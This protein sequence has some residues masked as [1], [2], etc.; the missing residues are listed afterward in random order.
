[1]YNSL[2]ISNAF[3]DS[4]KHPRHPWMEPSFHDTLPSQKP[5]QAHQ[6]QALGKHTQKL[7]KR[8]QLQ[9]KGHWWYPMVPKGIQFCNNHRQLKI[10]PGAPCSSSYFFCNLSKR[11]RSLSY[12]QSKLRP[13]DALVD[14]RVQN[15]HSHQHRFEC[16]SA[17]IP[18][19][20]Q[21]VYQAGLR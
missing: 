7:C 18:I 8:S 11:L 19:D 13:L 21:K 9:L 6:D 4:Y 16:P 5:L 15:H 10:D 3:F 2:R 1:V 17:H 20:I 12:L 14:P